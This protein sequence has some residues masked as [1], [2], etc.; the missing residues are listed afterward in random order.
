MKRNHLFHAL[1]ALTSWNFHLYLYAECH[2]STEKLERLNA[3]L[4]MSEL[5]HHTELKK[6]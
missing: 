2:E 5:F 4:K 3:P 6:G 1:Q